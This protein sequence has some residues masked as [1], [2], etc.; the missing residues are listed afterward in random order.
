MSQLTD[1]ECSKCESGKIVFF[2]EIRNGLK[3]SFIFQCNNCG[4]RL[5]FNSC[6]M[7]DDTED[8]NVSSILGITA[9]GLGYYHL[10]EFLAHLDIPLMSY[11][12]YHKYEEY[13]QAE[14]SK[15]AKKLEEE[16]LAE[17]IRLAK[18][19]NEVDSAGNALI[20]VE[21]DGSW[22]KR[23]YTNSFS[24]LGG[25]AAIV[26]LRTKKVLYS[27]VKNKYCHICKIA[28][29]KNV[30]PRKHDCNKNFDGPSSGMETKII[31]EGFKFCAEKGARFN[32]FV[33]DGDSSTYKALRDLRLYEDPY[34]S[35]EKFECI[36]HLF[37]NFLKHF[38]MLLKSS[39]MNIKG[40][41]LLSLDIGNLSFSVLN[42]ISNML[43]L[44]YTI[45]ISQIK[46]KYFVYIGRNICKGIRLAARYWRESSADNTEK[47]LNLERDIMNAF[48]HYLGIHEKCAKYFCTKTTTPEA[49]SIIQIMKETGVYYEVLD[50]CQSYFG[51][52]AKSL[53]AGYC[54]NR[55]EGFNS[56]IAKSI[57]KK[58][59]HWFCKQNLKKLPEIRLAH[60]YIGYIYSWETYMQLIGWVL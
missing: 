48:A 1:F 49:L 21:F 47:Y 14:Y 16:A 27:A 36:N 45:V 57:G 53:I 59:Y 13:I 60:Y 28:Q 23:S 44:I 43:H 42:G 39:R 18:A 54:T 46:I 7:H 8:I 55:T 2:K 56:L 29:S 5:R 52:N 22:E 4:N 3:S 17:E 26:G 11:V 35:I 20:A 40:R 19:S 58:L 12:T 37:R 25:C 33:G 10:Q 30:P 50:L 15:L 41:K 6:P 51:K 32:K 24:S 34:V 9:V 31:I 38:K